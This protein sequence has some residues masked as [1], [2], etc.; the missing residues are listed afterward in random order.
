MFQCL[1]Q[2]VTFLMHGLARFIGLGYSKIDRLVANR[3]T[4]FCLGRTCHKAPLAGNGTFGEF[5]TVAYIQAHQISTS[6]RSEATWG[7]KVETGEGE[8][9]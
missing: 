4:D 3:A 6:R 7:R 1:S 8:R 2:H 5:S 9:G